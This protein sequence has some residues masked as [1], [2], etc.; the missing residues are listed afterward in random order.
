MRRGVWVGGPTKPRLSRAARRLLK[1]HKGDGSVGQVLDVQSTLGSG[2]EASAKGNKRDFREAGAY[3][4][5]GVT[6]YDKLVE[7]QL[8]P[9]VAIKDNEMHVANRYGTTGLH[10]TRGDLVQ[11][12]FA[13]HGLGRGSA[14]CV[15]VADGIILLIECAGDVTGTSLC[16]LCVSAGWRRPC[17]TCSP[18]KPWPWPGSS[19]SPRYAH[20][21]QV[22]IIGL[23]GRRRV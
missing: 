8:Q 22:Y 9:R 23:C 12:E 3:I 6:E 5:Y 13:R 10:H 14:R 19:A 11:E 21:R 18:M 20:G 15:T 17:L 4:D 2:E 16:V 1:K 7:D